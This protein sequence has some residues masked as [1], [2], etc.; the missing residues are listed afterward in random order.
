VLALTASTSWQNPQKESPKW[1]ED[2]GLIVKRKGNPRESMR[3][4]WGLANGHEGRNHGGMSSG[5]K[6]EEGKSRVTMNL[7]WAGVR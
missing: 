6:T 1:S 5:P 2:D 7:P 4:A 3:E